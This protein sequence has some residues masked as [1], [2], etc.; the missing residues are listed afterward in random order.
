MEPIVLSGWGIAASIATIAAA[1]TA[2]ISLIYIARQA[3]AVRE[4]VGRMREQTDVVRKHKKVDRAYDYLKRYDDPNF[5]PV[6]AEAINF[7]K[8]EDKT[9]EEK[10]KILE[11]KEDPEHV[12]LKS[13][14][15]YALNFFD[16]LAI[17]YNPYSA[18]KHCKFR[19]NSSLIKG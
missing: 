8:R 6:A 16:E 1:V 2:I 13:K 12:S 18:K 17:M 7:L 3:G 19:L 4:Q 5:R 15:V 14:V 11:D 10:W 9:L